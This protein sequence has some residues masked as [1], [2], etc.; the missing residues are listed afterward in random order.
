M[1]T[2]HPIH[3][4]DPVL[5]ERARTMRKDAVPAERKLWFFLR[6]RRLSGYKFRRQEAIGPFIAD[7]YCAEARLVVEL[8]GDTHAEKAAYDA[9]RTRW[10]ETNGYEVVRFVNHYVHRE[11]EAVL[12][13]ILR[14]CDERK[15][16]RF[17]YGRTPHP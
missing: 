7:F 17:I 1:G 6:N 15:V 9:R 16:A 2:E 11:L 5:L 4:I 8:D 14:H 10:L 12:L 3:R 13:T